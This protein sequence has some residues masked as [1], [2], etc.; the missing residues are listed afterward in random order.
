[1]TASAMTTYSTGC[2]MNTAE[3]LQLM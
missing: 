2:Y 1:M 3:E